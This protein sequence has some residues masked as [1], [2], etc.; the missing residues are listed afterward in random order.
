MKK[1]EREAVNEFVALV[2]GKTW[3]RTSHA[4][5]GDW[6]G[7]TDYGFIMDG[8]VKFFVSNGMSYFEEQVRE[9][10]KAIRMF[11]MKKDYY[12]RLLRGQVEKDNANAMA[13]G[14][15]NIKLLDIG[16]LSPESNDQYDFFAPY[17]LIEIDGRQI[18]H[19]TT[20]LELAI[21]SDEL[22]A[23]IEECSRRK[24]F[25]A[26]AVL[27]PDFIFCGVRF[28]SCDNLYQIRI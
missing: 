15:Y 19:H 5:T 11:R 4:C 2:G 28:N 18:R 7:T 14:L 1:T 8:R 3:E 27:M 22:E 24:I 13:E 17:A 20:N 9:W 10:I 12:L 21:M 23:H 16:I 25:T 26:G 6:R